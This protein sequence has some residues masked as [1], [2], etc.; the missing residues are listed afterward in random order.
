[1]IAATWADIRHA[2]FDGN[3]L[4]RRLL[5]AVV[6]FSTLITTVVT[7]IELYGDYRHDLG[8]IDAT[9]RFVASSNV[10]ALEHSVWQL[11]GEAVRTQ[12]EGLLRLPDVAFASVEGAGGVRWTAGAAPPSH[13]KEALLALTH[14][15]GG[16]AV[17]IGTLRVVA[18]VDRVIA[19][20][21]SRALF[22]LLANGVKTLVVALFLLL[23]FQYLVARHLAKVARFVRDVDPLGAATGVQPLVL[24][25]RPPGGPP[26]AL[27]AVVGAINALMASLRRAREEIDASQRR[28]AESELR[29][30][31][32]LE[33]AGYGLWDCD[34]ANGSVF[35]NAECAAIVGLEP[36]A[37]APGFSKWLERIH[38]DDLEAC[39]EGL[40]KHLRDETSLLRLEMRLRHERLGWRWTLLR[41]RIV[42]R[43]A[44]GAPTRAL[45]TLV[46]F[47]ELRQA[48]AALSE[49]NRQLETRVRER[50]LAL[51]AARDEAER[52]N[53]AKSEFLSRMSHELRTPLNGILGFAQVLERG[54]GLS[55]E[56]ARGLRVIG[57]SGRHLTTLIDDI[58]DL[59]RIDARKFELHPT[60]VD[61]PAFLQ[62]VGDLIRVRA[63]E[64]GLSFACEAAPDLPATLRVDE[65]R[66]RQVLLNLLSNAVKF[67]DRGSV[68]L[69]VHR[70]RQDGP[71][72]TARLRF[73][74]CDSGIGMDEGQLARLFRPFEQ[75]AEA[76]RREGGS[77]L[78]LAIS[79]Q[80]VGLM[81]GEVRVASRPGEGSVFSFEIELPVVR[82]RPREPAV[83]AGP[84][85]A[86][87]PAAPPPGR[88]NPLELALRG[89][90]IL[91]VEDNE[92]NR[93]L[94]LNVLNRVHMVVSVAGD[95]QQALDL[96]R[97]QRFDG[98]LMDCLMPV[99][100]GYAATRALRDELQL[101]DLPVI[102]MTANAMPADRERALAAGMNDHIAKPFDVD[103]LL[104]TL[105]RWV[106]PDGG[107][108]RAQEGLAAACPPADA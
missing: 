6:G 52:A 46:D 83:A 80:L 15:Q 104:A 93:E 88:V 94:A 11:D 19:R 67:T 100:D 27:D 87:V 20:I 25:R 32:G 41:G 17:G 18:N 73:E 65:K 30:R 99:M 98:V 5:V 54:G 49:A 7:G 69:R 76:A 108:E 36:A 43:D 103:R 42:A 90:R 1:M 21:W 85:P 78:G 51:E 48:Q 68:S 75:V 58:L 57:E 12:L 105:A 23:V 8:E 96:L 40:R 22:E 14:E 38:P 61:M 97:T 79:Q 55:A 44:A 86:A 2:L 70:L 53:R 16:R 50:T 107:G 62:G 33:A 64:A 28:L 35:V 72:A 77:G 3:G 101:R 59:A 92:I 66:L 56:Q 82:E 9:F 71:A 24:D 4:A 106:R 63:E 81:G 47:T 31:L 89:A 84:A 60:E 45:G 39:T 29:F 26:D 10:P 13:G 95:G 91:L 102:A 37:L 34:L 74:V